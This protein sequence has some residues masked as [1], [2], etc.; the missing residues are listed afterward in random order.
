L[1]LSGT[2]GRP[3]ILFAS[4]NLT[5][6]TPILTNLTAKDTYEFT[7]TNATAASCRFFRVMPLR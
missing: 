4:T 3:F 6:W 5:D 7:D 2:A 1:H